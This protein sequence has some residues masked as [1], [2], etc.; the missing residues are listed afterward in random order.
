MHSLNLLPEQRKHLLAIRERLVQWRSGLIIAVAGITL[1]VGILGGVEWALQEQR[2][3]SEEDLENWQTLSDKRESGQIT[4]TTTRLNTTITELQGLFVPFS[5]VHKN[6][7]GLLA[8]FPAE[9]RLTSVTVNVDGSF[10]LRGVALT[11][12]TFLALR[13]ALEKSPLITK[14]ATTST[15][16]QRENL[17]FEYTGQLILQP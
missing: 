17:P 2:K 10:T 15:A 14:L 3:S 11:R 6:L 12:A 4:T 16:N 8:T 9:V 1:A 13:T 7:R 5:S